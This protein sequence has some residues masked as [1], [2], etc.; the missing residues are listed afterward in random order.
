MRRKNQ[1]LAHI[2]KPFSKRA[3]RPLAGVLV[4]F[5]LAFHAISG[6]RGV[7]AMFKETRKL[8]LIKAELEKTVA[9]RE[10]LD[11]KVRALSSDSLD[12]DLLDEQARRVLGLAGKNEVVYFFSD[13][14]AR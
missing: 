14:S 1:F 12:L 9:E 10:A 13:A 3:A 7:V 4:L 2:R 5:Y 8:E 11:T 6:E